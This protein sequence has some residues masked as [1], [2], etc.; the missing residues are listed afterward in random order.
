LYKKILVPTDGSGSAE[1]ALHHAI[2][3]AKLS[4]GELTIL[5]VIETPFHRPPTDEEKHKI[6]TYLEE[7][8]KKVEKAGVKVK[9]SSPVGDPKA[10]IKRICEKNKADLIVMGYTGRA[11]AIK[12]LIGSTTEYAVEH[13]KCPVLVIK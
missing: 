8:K 4:G 1:R 10:E 9:T 7:V 3:I 5:R 6:E 2:E 13:L 12:F 11:K